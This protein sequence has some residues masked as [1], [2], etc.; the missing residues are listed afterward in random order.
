MKSPYILGLFHNAITNNTVN[1]KLY[2]TDVAIIRIRKDD[3]RDNA[4]SVTS[5]VLQY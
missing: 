1:T 4:Q 3:M 5:Q 2:S